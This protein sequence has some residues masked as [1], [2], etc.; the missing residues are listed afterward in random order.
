MPSCS[1]FSKPS[2]TSRH[3]CL[4]ADLTHRC[5]DPPHPPPWSS[6]NPRPHPRSR[7]LCAY[8][9]PTA[10]QAEVVLCAAT[11]FNSGARDPFLSGAQAPLLAAPTFGSVLTCL[12]MSPPSECSLSGSRRFILC[13]PTVRPPGTQAPGG[14]QEQG[15]RG[16]VVTRCR[17]E[18]GQR[19]QGPSSSPETVS[20]DSSFLEN[21]IFECTNGNRINISSFH[22]AQL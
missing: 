2:T 15:A 7:G 21:L 17:R 5:S 4:V 3:G 9:A 14:G 16:E 22:P 20:Q 19:L 12:P 1:C 10:L 11:P 13:Q 18:G 6:D 8:P